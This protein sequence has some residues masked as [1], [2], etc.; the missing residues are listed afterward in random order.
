MITP[1]SAYLTEHAKA[2]RCPIYQVKISE[3]RGTVVVTEPTA[4]WKLDEIEGSRVDSIG[5]A[6][7]TDHSTV[8]YVTGK[9]GNAA[10]FTRVNSEYLSTADQTALRAGA[11]DWSFACWV[12]FDSLP[13]GEHVFIASKSGSSV[14]QHE[15]VL[16]WDGATNSRIKF[17]I[18]NNAGANSKAVSATTFGAVSTGVWYFIVLRHTTASKTI[19][20]RI[21]AGTEDT[22]TYTTTNANDGTG[23][24]DLGADAASPTVQSMDGKID[25]AGWW[26]GHLLT[27]G[28]IT[29]LYNSGDALNLI[30]YNIDREV[31]TFCTSFPI[32][33][34][35]LGPEILV[36]IELMKRMEVDRCRLPLS[37]LTFLLQDIGNQAT[38]VISSDVLV[39]YKCDLFAGFYHLE[40]AAT[41]VN[42]IQLYSG[43]IAELEYDRGSWKF[44]VRSPLFGPQDKILFNGASSQL[45]TNISDV[46]TSLDLVDASAFDNAF[47]LP[48]SSRRPIIFDDGSYEICVYRSKSGNTLGSIQRP[49]SAGYLVPP[50]AGAAASH[51]IG[52]TVREL[53]KLGEINIETDEMGAYATDAMHPRRLI[54]AIFSLSDKHGFGEANLELNTASMDALYTELG[55]QFQ[56]RFI[57]EEST[58]GKR[59]LEEQ[60]CL[61]LAG[62]PFEDNQGK[63]GIKLYSGPQL[64]SPP[65]DTLTDANILDFPHWIR[66]AEKIINKVVY[67]YDYMPTIKQYT[68][69]YVQQDDTLIA[70]LGREAI[71]EI[72]AKGVHGV[73]TAGGGT[74][75]WFSATAGVL[76][77]RALAHIARFG[78]E[79]PIIGITTLLSK[80]LLECGDEVNCSFSQAINL[81]LSARS[82]T[83][84]PFEIVSMRHDFVRNTIDMELLGFPA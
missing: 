44:T 2:S 63:F 4:Y 30:D 12:K 28:E 17:T 62:T 42:Y 39:G 9:L 40:W 26:Q 11:R 34:E 75:S 15:W 25:E 71:L 1:S 10:Q 48:E 32:T 38:D 84:E 3:R 7:L 54:E 5:T 35:D 67:R 64:N 8:T 82:I 76:L 72:L 43:T 18:Y 55:S 47:D 45:N 16:E 65:T 74:Q 79:A 78:T 61:V 69:M 41:P 13:G 49:G 59:L 22:D 14:N 56:M 37:V 51:N 33:G 29:S 52:A 68:S 36:P 21:N 60:F 81:G 66:N 50:R 19:G 23:D 83:N 58:N 57:F 24:F 46:S 70:D 20:I 27:S 80:N 77:L 31:A 73:A 6:H 53:V